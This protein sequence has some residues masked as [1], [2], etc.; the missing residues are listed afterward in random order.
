M[1][2]LHE[3]V[4]PFIR[5]ALAAPGTR[6]VL[7]IGAG[8]GALTKRLHE[9]GFDVSACDLFPEH[10][11]FG[12]V[13]CRRADLAEALPYED[14]SFDAAVAVEVTEHLL[15]PGRFFAECARVLKRGGMLVTTTPNVV[16]L[17]SRLRFLVSGFP[18]G[19][20]PLGPP[21]GGGLK[22]VMPLG[23]DQ[24]RHAAAARGLEL[25]RHSV[26]RYQRSSLFLLPLW[27]LARPLTWLLGPRLRGHNGLG[28]LLGRVLV[29]AYR[30][31]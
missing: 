6:R 13:E 23:L 5:D 22:H 20:C 4:W 31:T 29:A 30:K 9:L 16:S 2:G 27:V 26:D 24:Y 12:E 7:D 3:R 11:A 14:G 15:D 17:K 21:G 25:V 10:F 8:E 19:F 18:G 28:L 1:P